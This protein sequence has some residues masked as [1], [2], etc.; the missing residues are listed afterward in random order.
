MGPKE[1]VRARITRYPNTIRAAT[2]ALPQRQTHA[3]IDRLFL[4]H[5]LEGTVGGNSKEARANELARYLIANPDAQ[6]DYGE[7]LSDTVIT[8]L[9]DELVRAH[10][11]YNNEFEYDRFKESYPALNRA[12][13]RDGFTVE[14]GA[15][16][17][18]LPDALET[19]PS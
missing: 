8:G 17:R 7:N 5:G 6:D 14:D 15:L 13:E 3:G 18:M 9:I 2:D 19:S 11:N 10:T 16:R 12:L 4:D 1:A